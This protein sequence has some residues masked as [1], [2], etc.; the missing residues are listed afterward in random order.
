MMLLLATV[1]ATTGCTKEDTS[2]CDRSC[3]LIV[4]AYDALGKDVT[5]ECVKDVS[6]YIFD[7]KGAFLKMYSELEIGDKVFVNRPDQDHLQVIGWANCNGYGA[8]LPVLEAGDSI[9]DAFVELFR[10]STDNA[11]AL[12]PS[13]L[14]YG[15][16][17]I[18]SE[19]T[20]KVLELMIKRKTASV[21]IT[22]HNLQNFANIY[23]EDFEYVV[24][25]TGDK[26]DFLGNEAGEYVKYMPESSF[27]G[28]DFV[29]PIFNILPTS[30]HLEIDIYHENQW[31]VTIIK[32]HNGKPLKVEDGKLL[33]I[34]IELDT[35]ISVSISITPWGVKEIWKD[36][37]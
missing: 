28:D 8:Q 27:I 36:F 32:D 10:S 5:D 29:T 20:A 19:G 34:L 9:G 13:D 6:I 22:T 25:E 11:L 23:E 15:S 17:D 37:N 18:S 33:N 35:Y 3:R 16:I 14:F 31:I 24:R 30:S 12:S 4:K 2:R 21:S 26:L 1:S 7:A